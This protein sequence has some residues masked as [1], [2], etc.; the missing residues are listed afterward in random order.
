MPHAGHDARIRG[1]LGVP[2]AQKRFHP[3]RLSV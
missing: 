2:R 1:N 3:H